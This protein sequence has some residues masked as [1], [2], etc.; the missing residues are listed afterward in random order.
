MPRRGRS[1]GSRGSLVGV[2]IV[3]LGLLLTS[4]G[5]P[6]VGRP[7]PARVPAAGTLRS[8]SSYD[9][10]DAGPG[11]ASSPTLRDGHGSDPLTNANGSFGS[12]AYS[13]VLGNDTVSSG[14]VN[15]P[16][17]V[18]PD[19]L[20][21]VAPNDTLWTAHSVPPTDGAENVT[22]SNL[23]SGATTIVNG[24]GNVTSW[25][26]DP[27]L[28]L[29]V[30][31]QV[32]PGQSK[33]Q[34]LAIS[35]AS[36]DV[37]WAP[38]TLPGEAP[39]VRIDPR[40]GDLWIPVSYGPGRNGSV[41]IFSPVP[42]ATPTN[43][44]VGPD[45]TAVTFDPALGVGLVA[46]SGNGD[47]SVVNDSRLSVRTVT[48]VLWSGNDS[49]GPGPV[50]PLG[51]A[52]DAT[53]GALLALVQSS[54]D[55]VLESVD[56]TGEWSD[57]SAQPLGGLATSLVVDAGSGAAWITI[58]DGAN[59]TSALLEE[60]A[61]APVARVAA[62]PG[63]PMV[64]AI[65]TATDQDYVGNVG[66]VFASVVNLSDPTSPLVAFGSGAGPRGG[67]YA[68]GTAFVVNSYSGRGAQGTGPDDLV[69]IDPV[70]AHVAPLAPWPLAGRAQAGTG[71]AGVAFDP[72]SGRLF[73]P[74]RNASSAVVLSAATGAYLATLSLPFAPVGVADDPTG[75]TV[76]FDSASGGLAAYRA[77]TLDRQAEWNASAPALGWNGSTQSLAVDA[78]TGQV[79]LL[80]PSA[81]PSTPSELDLVS[82]GNGT[83]VSVD[84]G[85]GV[86]AVAVAFDPVDGDGY[87]AES[88][89]SL[90]A[91]N[92]T[93]AAI[94]EDVPLAG[95]PSSLGF[96]DRRVAI[97]AALSLS[98]EVA[99]FNGSSPV[100]LTAA[101]L[102]LRT[103][104]DPDGL[105]A[106][107]P[108]GELFVSDYGSGTVDEYSA[109]PVVAG[110]S[111]HIDVPTV[112][113]LPGD[114][115]TDDVGAPVYFDTL[116]GGGTPPL[117]IDYSG[118]PG[119]C[120]SANQLHLFC[121]PTGNGTLEPRVVV[122]DAKGAS[123]AASTALTVVDAPSVQVGALPPTAEGVPAVVRI[124]FQVLGGV[125]PYEYAVDS[126][127][128]GGPPRN[129]TWSGGST[130]V[131][132]SYP[133]LGAYTA[134]VLVRDLF[135]RTATASVAVHVLAPVQVSVA[136]A[137]GAT[138]RP[139]L[140]V[141]VTLV[142]KASYGVGPYRFL[143]G[144]SSNGTDWAGTTDG[145]TSTLSV[146]FPTAGAT[147]VEVSVMDGANATVRSNLSLFVTAAPP[148]NAS[149]S[150]VPWLWVGIPIVA[151]AAALGV[152]LVVW[153]ARSSKRAR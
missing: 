71:A 14:A 19:Q 147:E 38:A 152:G 62:L 16:Y 135:G 116:G 137:A 86:P 115:T 110:L 65:D 25:A 98:D 109:V 126:G 84:L 50:P 76:Y 80:V 75:G 51:F 31:L 100:D 143:W 94:V 33:A 97:E 64:Q 42:G 12:V 140:G 108:Q 121:D 17:A 21:Y 113:E 119:G 105:V 37:A 68:D 144:F 39:C 101:P 87:V 49:S 146:A 66:Q 78:A 83:I 130:N 129:G 149:G 92:L 41:L 61:G 148:A 22:L 35:T 43:V 48:G 30:L 72:S 102:L 27:A 141:R 28:E 118:L 73:V 59:R 123:A 9:T 120:S 124:A 67:V 107:A 52:F 53:T 138:S 79:L 44:T 6:A 81:S 139:E 57:A 15:Q 142:A 74:L 3:A 112:G 23:S 4:T 133:S 20:L 99:V 117:A 24:V 151:G 114:L 55:S 125:G 54:P 106:N 136:P 46:D 93:R 32:P 90:L 128:L 122:T 77:S 91:V 104:P 103:G 95:G 82:P 145:N 70:Q 132:E 36:D 131:T 18:G 153:R 45:P 8:G 96:D 11:L 29:V 26:F 58:Q 150:S 5:G 13:W 63:L 134:T 2:V 34:L 60:P 56:P 111:V 47:L 40:T 1:T 85:L 127:I 10:S 7:A 88:N 69:A 89:G